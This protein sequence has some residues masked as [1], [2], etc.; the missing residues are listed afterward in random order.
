MVR[1]RII[2]AKNVKII[3]NDP[4]A[5]LEGS[6]GRLTPQSL[7]QQIGNYTPAELTNM[8]RKY[9]YIRPKHKLL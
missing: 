9:K 5:E 2:Q 3:L 1:L 7:V 8:C 6:K 4:E